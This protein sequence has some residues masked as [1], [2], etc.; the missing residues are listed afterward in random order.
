[1]RTLVRDGVDR[2]CTTTTLIATRA[3]APVYERLGYR[4]VGHLQMWER[5]Y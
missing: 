2:G 4:D 5:V 3:G 1:M